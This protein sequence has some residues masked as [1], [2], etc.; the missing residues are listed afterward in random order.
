MPLTGIEIFKLLPK[1]NCGECGVPT[2]LAF[3]MAL[4]AGKAE[5]VACPYVS[6]EA[7]EKL[8]EASAPPIRPVTIGV[9]EGAIKIGGETVLF[10]HEKRFEN[11]PG[12][13]IIISDTMTEDEVSSRL[14]RFSNLQFERVGLTLRP[15]LLAAKCDSQDAVKFKVLVEKIKQKGNAS[16][17]LMSDNPDML[18]AGLEVCADSRPLLYAATKDN[19][20][21]V[22]ALAKDKSC[23]MAVKANNLD[24]LIELTTKLDQDGIKD[25]VIDSGARKARQAFEEQIMI[26]RAALEKKFR[27]LGY[28]TIILA[29]E[30]ADNPMKEALIAATFVAKYGGIIVLSDFQGES[31]FPLLVLR[32]NIF[33]DPQRPLATTEGIY[34]IGN[35][36]NNSPVLL[37]SNFSLTYFIV[38]GEMENSRI[39]SYLLVKDTEGLSVMTAWAAGKFGA[40]TIAPF[41]K[42]CG[43]ANE[44]KHRKLI[45]PGYI[46]M[47]SGGLEEELPDWEILIGPREGAHIPAYLKTWKP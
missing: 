30:M 40:D 17:I 21:K 43:I 23:P 7:K 13:A 42:K 38:S 6:E 10:R 41:V 29:N 46:A 22:A 3:A 47:E 33:T 15:E 5:L 9:G 1:T 25:I 36:D 35:T 37:T 24:E 19:I 20:D 14:Y 18:A 45:I 28:P 34:K 16:I 32:L 12:F 39:P 44:I 26:R 4:A 31:L 2:C 27:P 8:E 11:P